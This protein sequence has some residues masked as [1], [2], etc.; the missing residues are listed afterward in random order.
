MTEETTPSPVELP[1]RDPSEPTVR[2]PTILLVE[3]DADTRAALTEVFT[4]HGYAVVAVDD[5]QK[6]Y[7]YLEHEQRPD[8]IV[9]DLWMPVMDGWTLAAAVTLG[10]LPSVPIVVVTASS[11]QLG[12]PVPP[13][14]VMRKPVNPERLLRLVDEVVKPRAPQGGA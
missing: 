4:D 11:A 13:R 1:L 14:Y 10:Q 8:A 9:L 12:Y 7:E 6:A 5:G 2:S 3:D